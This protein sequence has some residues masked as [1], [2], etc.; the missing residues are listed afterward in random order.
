MKSSMKIKRKLPE[1]P[2]PA[3]RATF[4]KEVVGEGKYTRTIDRPQKL[5][6]TPGKWV[7]SAPKRR[8]KKQA[9]TNQPHKATVRR[10]ENTKKVLE[11]YDKG[12][13]VNQIICETGLAQTT[14]NRYIRNAGKGSRYMQRY[15][16]DAEIVQMY[17]EGLSIMDMSE[18]LDVP[19]HYV[20]NMLRRLRAEGKIG[21]RRKKWKEK[22]LSE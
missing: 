7:R 19:D 8:A 4:K 1:P 16:H 13:T 15:K 18:K 9:A 14:V 11:L 20:R 2:R 6:M 10:L 3:T 21:W 5:H 17:D 22:A 12:Y